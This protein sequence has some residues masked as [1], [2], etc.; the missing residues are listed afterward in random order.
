MCTKKHVAPLKLISCICTVSGCEMKVEY[1]EG[2]YF[3]LLASAFHTECS[4]TVKYMLNHSFLPHLR[5][6]NSPFTLVFVT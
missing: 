2:K 1:M 4:I 3:F 6:D 5:I